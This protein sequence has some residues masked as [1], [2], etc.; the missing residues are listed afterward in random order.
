VRTSLLKR[1]KKRGVAQ[2]EEHLFCKSKVIS[3]P[4][5]YLKEKRERERERE[6]DRETDRDIMRYLFY[7]NAF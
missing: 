7:H 3:S 4:Q 1:K 5:S 2:V 6:R